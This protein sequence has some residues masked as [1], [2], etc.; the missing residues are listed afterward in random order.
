MRRL[1]RSGARHARAGFDRMCRRSVRAA[2]AG[3][4]QGEA[5]AAPRRID[6]PRHARTNQDCHDDRRGRGAGARF[7]MDAPPLDKAAPP[8][9]GVR[10]GAVCVPTDA[11]EWD[12]TLEWNSTT[13][14]VVEVAAG[15]ETG[16]G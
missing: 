1:G 15:G 16:L 12:G 7:N 14:V 8:V 3:A 13:L 5:G 2:H 4:G 10:V 11:P 6:G 9:E